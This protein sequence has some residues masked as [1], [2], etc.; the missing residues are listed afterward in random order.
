MGTNE[1]E[2]SLKRLKLSETACSVVRRKVMSAKVADAFRERRV[3]Q[4][5]NSKVWRE[6]KK[7]I[8]WHLRQGYL[9]LWKEHTDSV[10][11]ALVQKHEKK[12]K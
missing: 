5:Q 2:H 3:A 6:V 1:V 8:P 4:I 9:H 12:V 10:K 7:E 11:R